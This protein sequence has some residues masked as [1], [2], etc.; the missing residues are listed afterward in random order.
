MWFKVGIWRDKINGFDKTT[1]IT[2]VLVVLFAFSGG[3]N[4]KIDKNPS[5]VRNR[6]EDRTLSIV[7]KYCTNNQI[8]I[9]S[10]NETYWTIINRLRYFFPWAC[11]IQQHATLLPYYFVQLFI[12]VYFAVCLVGVCICVCVVISNVLV[13]LKWLITFQSTD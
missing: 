12:T 9:L 8:R 1:S 10:L 7:G 5:N 4:D 3:M 13:C 11:G 2:I 6:H